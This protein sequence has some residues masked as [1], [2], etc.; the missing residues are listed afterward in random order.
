MYS[1][2]YFQQILPESFVEEVDDDNVFVSS[3]ISS[4]ASLEKVKS[5]V[6]IVNFTR[7]LDDNNIL[8]EFKSGFRKK[9]S[10][11]SCLSFLNDNI[12]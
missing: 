2:V 6:H 7:F 9:Y 4:S 11:K 3:S 5:Y 12:S 1:F 10:T 8:Y